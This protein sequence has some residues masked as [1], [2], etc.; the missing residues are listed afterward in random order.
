M[1]IG[2]LGTGDVGKALGNAFIKLGHEVRMGS[3]EAKNPK[4]LEW[5]KTAGAKASTGT[6]ADAA[7]FGEL[8]VLATLGG[9]TE[10]VAKSITDACKGKTVWDAANP[11]EFGPTGPHLS[12]AGNDSLGE[13]VQKAMPGAHVV[14]CFNTVGHGLMFQPKVAGGPPTM[15]IAGNADAAKKQTTELLKQFGWET[16]DVG[17][18]E[19]SRYLEAMCLVWVGYALRTGTWTHAFKLLK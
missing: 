1:K 2:V 11:L 16:A 5:A 6:L 8:V 9:A 18:I 17:G 10:A 15:F 7:K 14:K 3:R 12:I 13:R 19:G 4:A